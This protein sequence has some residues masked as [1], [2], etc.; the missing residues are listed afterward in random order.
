MNILALVGSYRKKGNTA[1]IVQMVGTQ[2]ETLAGR[3]GESL[4]F[5]VLYLGDMDIRSCRGCRT[6][7]DR[8]EDKCPLKDDIPAIKAK[9]DAADAFILA[10]PVYVDDVSGLTKNFMDRL[11][12]IC[13]RPAFA[14]KC[15]F[16]LAT[17]GGSP[18][19]HTL[20][21]MNTALVTWGF[22]LVG[23][24]GYKMGAL[25]PLDEMERYRSETAKIAEKLFHAVAERHALRPSFVSLLTFK[26]QQLAWQRDDP[27]TYDYAYRKDQGWLEP[28]RT[29][30]VT[31][32]ASPVK[33]ALARAMGAAIAPFVI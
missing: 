15:A 29:F 19:R 7:F 11:A 24:A 10:S 33:V 30:Y 27:T 32:H 25:T 16:S 23:K 22:H 31:H 4:T 6:C 18:T 9:M 8:G 17:V 14:G 20:G 5:E 28:D 21:T 2:L 1:R 3:D 26:I 12:Y 13:H